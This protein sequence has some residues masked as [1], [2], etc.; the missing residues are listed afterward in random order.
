MSKVYYHVVQVRMHVHEKLLALKERVGEQCLGNH[1][2]VGI[3][4]LIDMLLEH[5]ANSPPDY[6]W[7]C[8]EVKKHPYRGQ[9]H[10]PRKTDIYG[11]RIASRKD[12]LGNDYPTGRPM[13]VYG[14]IGPMKFLP[15]EMDHQRIVSPAKNKNRKVCIDC[16][17]EWLIPFD[18]CWHRCGTFAAKSPDEWETFWTKEQLAIA[19]FSDEEIAFLKP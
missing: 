17:F 5:W 1:N 3:S 13:P 7:L 10:Q 8:E 11:H 9:R 2:M 4:A 6:D 19:E 14:S 12:A 16:G 15:P 18:Y